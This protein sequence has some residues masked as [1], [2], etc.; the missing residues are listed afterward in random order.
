MASAA[1]DEAAAAATAGVNGCMGADVAGAVPAFAAT[2]FAAVREV[3]IGSG[4]PG[5]ARW[6]VVAGRSPRPPEEFFSVALIGSVPRQSRRVVLAAVPRPLARTATGAGRRPGWQKNWLSIPDA[7]E[8]AWTTA[9]VG[10][11]LALRRRTVKPIAQMAPIVRRHLREMD[12]AS[13]NLRKR[14]AEDGAG[15][16]FPRVIWLAAITMGRLPPVEAALQLSGG[17]AS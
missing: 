7:T 13:I 5:A 14:V 1:E 4:R 2:V 9:S 16:H 17:S 6:S 15:K 3:A 10:G 11:V 12:H 8:R